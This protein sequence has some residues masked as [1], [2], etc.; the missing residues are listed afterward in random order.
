MLSARQ[1]PLLWTACLGFQPRENRAS[2]Y[3]GFL[4]LDSLPATPPASRSTACANVPALAFQA[5]AEVYSEAAK[6]KL[7]LADAYKQNEWA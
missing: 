5:A 7:Q 1:T 2:M 3:A 4:G 6:V